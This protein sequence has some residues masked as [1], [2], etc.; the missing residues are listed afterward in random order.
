MENGFLSFHKY[1][2]QQKD[3]YLSCPNSKQET[4]FKRVSEDS[5]AGMGLVPLHLILTALFTES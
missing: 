4:S 5:R 2:F 1:V 3:V